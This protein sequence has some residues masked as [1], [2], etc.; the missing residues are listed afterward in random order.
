MS[1]VEISIEQLKEGMFVCDL[2]LPWMKNPFFRSRFLIKSNDE[3]N[4]LKGA[5]CK[6]L[7]IDLTKGVGLTNAETPSTKSS[8]TEDSPG[9]PIEPFPTLPPKEPADITVGGTKPATVKEVKQRHR[10]AFELRKKTLAAIQEMNQSLAKGRPIEQ[11]KVL[12]VLDE[13][14]C[15][16]DENEQ[17]ILASL[18]V[19]PEQSHLNAHL[20]NTLTLALSLGTTLGLD[21]QNLMVLAQAALFHDIGWAKLPSFLVNKG[22]ALTPQE[23]ELARQHIVLGVAQLTKSPELPAEVVD[24]VSSHHNKTTATAEQLSDLSAIDMARNILSVVDAYDEITHG[25]FGHVGAI[26]G[27]AMKQLFS[28][29]AAGQFHKPVLSA[30]IHHMGVYPVGSAVQLSDQSKGIVVHQTP[31]APLKPQIMLCYD[32]GGGPMKV[33]TLVDIHSMESLSVERFLDPLSK[34]DDPAGLLAIT[35]R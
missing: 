10:A 2:D 7:H 32:I 27:R 18:T 20:Y 13:L 16:L 29:V 28:K 15:Q 3:I 8:E 24:L 34:Q 12:P 6:K 4:Q 21:K 22:R 1:I 14:A 17:A 25:L 35:V 11:E 5:G 33:Q 30:F 31:D 9:L 19:K 23:N 26:P